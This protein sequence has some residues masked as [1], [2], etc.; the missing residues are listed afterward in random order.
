MDGSASVRFKQHTPRWI[1]SRIMGCYN[2]E[3]NNIHAPGKGSIPT[4]GHLG[5]RE[6]D[7]QK[8]YLRDGSIRV[9]GLST[10]F[11]KCLKQA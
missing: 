3:S 5:P 8:E 9:I 1:S 6:Q 7:V 11:I 10:D 2:W 4:N